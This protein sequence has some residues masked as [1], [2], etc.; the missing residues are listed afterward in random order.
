MRKVKNGWGNDRTTAAGGLCG[1]S[2]VGSACKTTQAPSRKGRSPAQHKDDPPP[3][4]SSAHLRRKR[5]PRQGGCVL[6]FKKLSQTHQ[7]QT[8]SKLGLCTSQIPRNFHWMAV[9]RSRR[10]HRCW[11]AT[12]L[13]ARPIV[14]SPPQPFPHHTKTVQNN[15]PFFG[16]IFASTWCKSGS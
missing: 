8:R 16:A 11:A 12:T 2:P 10:R 7:R 13:A 4:P 3:P 15:A 14:T 1:R 5:Q 9:A 6:I